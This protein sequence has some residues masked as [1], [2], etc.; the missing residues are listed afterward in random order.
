MC[1][2]SS[3]SLLQV[4]DIQREASDVFQLLFGEW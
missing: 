1:P 3:E 2:Y 4:L